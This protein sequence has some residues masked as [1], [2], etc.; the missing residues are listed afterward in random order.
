MK[1]F[2]PEKEIYRSFLARTL[3]RQLLL[4]AGEIAATKRGNDIESIHRMRVAS[5]RLRTALW[6][7]KK[8]FSSRKLRKWA[9]KFRTNAK[10]LGDIRDTDVHIDF[11][12]RFLRR[13][14]TK[15]YRLGIARLHAALSKKRKRMQTRVVETVGDLEKS[16]T[17]EDMREA[18]RMIL[19]SQPV[20]ISRLKN[21]FVYKTAKNS[22]SKCLDELLSFELYV[23]RPERCEE[24]HEM[25]IAAKH[26]RYTLEIF[27]PLYAR[28]IAPIRETVRKV[29]QLLGGIHD[30]DIWNTFLPRFMVFEKEVMRMESAPH[31]SISEFEKGIRYFIKERDR[32][33]FQMYEQF[34]RAWERISRE[35]MWGRLNAILK[36]PLRAQ[37]G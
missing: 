23:Q 8:Y 13:P 16:G 32:Y 29:Q 7:Y 27:E 6:L 1:K 18:L 22:V 9:K 33:R 17:I 21:K 31:V 3:L 5:R 14:A 19:Q 36:E 34:T 15:S 2:S 30:C 20:L 11:I 28:R 35:K 25:R 10:A 4:I 37:S 26:L 24:L 12:A